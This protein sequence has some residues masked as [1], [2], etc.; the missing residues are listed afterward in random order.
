MLNQIDF[1]LQWLWPKARTQNA[2]QPES[3]T[4]TLASF[5]AL[6]SLSGAEH[7]EFRFAAC[8]PAGPYC[9]GLETQRKPRARTNPLHFHQQLFPLG[10]FPSESQCASLQSAPALVAHSH[11]KGSP[12]QTPM[13]GSCRGPS[14][15]LLRAALE[16]KDAL[17]MLRLLWIT[18]ALWPSEPPGYLCSAHSIPAQTGRAESQLKP[19]I[20]LIETCPWT[21]VEARARANF[22]LCQNCIYHMPGILKGGTKLPPSP[23]T[24][25]R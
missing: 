19:A 8:S 15:L 6:P 21:L 5:D 22:S 24:K 1:A 3:V 17:R 14:L 12:A 16:V 10:K 23:P 18:G 7:R 25:N 11:S 4:L 20:P 2:F 13:P 9:T